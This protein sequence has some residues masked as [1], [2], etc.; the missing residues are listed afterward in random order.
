VKRTRLL[1]IV[2]FVVSVGFLLILEAVTLADQTPMNH[3][4]A[5][6]RAMY[7][8]ETWVFMWLAASLGYL[9]GHF[10]A[11]GRKS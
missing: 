11:S 2:W 6:V 5:V 9:C 4:T 3:I 1:L 10:F 8:K 7:A